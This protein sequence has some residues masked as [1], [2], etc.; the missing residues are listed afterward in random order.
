MTGKP[1]EYNGVPVCGP[2]GKPIDQAGLNKLVSKYAADNN[3]TPEQAIEHLN[4]N[5]VNVADF[6]L[7]MLQDKSEAWTEPEEE[8]SFDGL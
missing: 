1:I 8:I 3:V 6:V 5:N 2:D 7:V 4:N